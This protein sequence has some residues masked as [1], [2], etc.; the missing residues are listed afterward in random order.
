MAPHAGG[1]DPFAS[2]YALAA[3]NPSPSERL[4]DPKSGE[5]SIQGA[6]AP[7][8][9]WG[10]AVPHSYVPPTSE[11]GALGAVASRVKSSIV[12]D[13][14]LPADTW[15]SRCTSEEDPVDPT[16]DPSTACRDAEGGAEAP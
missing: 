11:G 9:D 7:S 8:A 13:R 1:A 6:E 16:S 3:S 14:C 15:G 10:G 2:M 12:V 4:K 5:E